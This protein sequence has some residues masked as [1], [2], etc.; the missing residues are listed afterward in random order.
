M[1][2]ELAKKEPA[3]KRGKDG[4]KKGDEK[5]T[6]NKRAAETDQKEDENQ[7]PV[8]NEGDQLLQVI[9]GCYR[10]TIL[11]SISWHQELVNFLQKSP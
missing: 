1:V 2:N 5:L 11:N 10:Y 8:I 9:S 6:L 4:K 7:H 3:V